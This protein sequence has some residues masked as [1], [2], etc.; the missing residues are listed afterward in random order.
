MRL[1]TTLITIISGAIFTQSAVANPD[2]TSREYKLLLNP[3]LFSYQTEANQV[4]SYF[5][6][7]KIGI[8]QAISRSVTGSLSLNKIRT[9]KFFDTVNTCQLQQIGYVFRERIENGNSEV[10][11]KFRSPDRYIADFEDLTSPTNGAETKLEADVSATSNDTFKVVYSHSTKT[12]NT[13]IINNFKDINTHFSGFKT[14]YGF[15]DS[16]PLSQISNLTIH[17]QVYKGAEIDLGSYDAKLSVTLWYAGTPSAHSIPLVAEASF[18]YEDPSADYSKKV[19]LRAKQAF[20]S[21]LALT[22]WNAINGT[23]KTQTVYQY[24]NGFCTQ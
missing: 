22:S 6:A 3:M 16:T 10:T 12:P 20:E 21:M 5:S 4:S 23:T 18:K 2:V 15:S 13:R 11:L 19:V 8:E 17:E 14:N 1:F 7:A 9:V 24:S